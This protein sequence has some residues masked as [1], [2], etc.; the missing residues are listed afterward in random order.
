MMRFQGDL[1]AT[2]LAVAEGRLGEMPAATFSDETALTVVMA[3]D[4]YPG[5]PKAGGSIIGLDSARTAGATV[6]HA[7]TRFEDG[8]LVASGGRVLAVTATGDDV[9]AAQANAYRGVDAIDF[10]EGFYRRDIGWRE[11][12]RAS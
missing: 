12:A 6:F 3:A 7:G 1:L 4:G 10:A 9:A 5:T 8:G 2:M 11:I